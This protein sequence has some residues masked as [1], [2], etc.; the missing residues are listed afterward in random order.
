MTGSSQRILQAGQGREKL[1]HSSSQL[2]GMQGV[3]LIIK[4]AGL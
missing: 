3:K 2:E 4:D 1:L